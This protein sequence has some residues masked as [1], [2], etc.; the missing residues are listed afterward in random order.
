VSAPAGRPLAQLGA[1][2]EGQGCAAASFGRAPQTGRAGHLTVDSVQRLAA[3]LE[4]RLIRVEPLDPRHEDD[5]WQAARD[6]EVWRFM[7]DDGG[8]SREAFGEWFRTGLAD[9]AAGAAVAFAVIDRNDGRAIGHTRFHSIALE[10]RRLEIGYTWYARRYWRTGVN[11]ETKLLLLTHA[12]E[13]LGCLRVEFKA[14]A[15]NERSRLALAALP[16]R[17][18]GT[19]RKHMLV[20]DGQRRDSAYYS[21]IDDEWPEVRANLQRRLERHLRDRVIKDP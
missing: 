14:D 20:Q 17:Y 15:R 21:I 2:A 12:F 5:L 6:P 18:E 13:N 11:V 8:T 16:A 19:F 10:H 7:P 1:V 9:I 4:G 3:S